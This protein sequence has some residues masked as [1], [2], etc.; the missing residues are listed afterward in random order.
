MSHLLYYEFQVASFSERG[1]KAYYIGDEQH[2]KEG[3]VDGLYQLVYF[4]PEMLLGSKEW[5][6]V[7]LISVYSSFLCAFIVD[8]YSSKVVSI[9]PIS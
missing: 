7:L 2:V 8:E 1:V 9:N 6:K 4:T 5:R 3:V